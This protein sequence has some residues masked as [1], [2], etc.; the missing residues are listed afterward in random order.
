MLHYQGRLKKLK[1]FGTA[2]AVCS[3]ALSLPRD[4]SAEE[5]LEE[6]LR[7]DALCMAVPWCTLEKPRGGLCFANR[8]S[9]L[10]HVCPED[11][12]DFRNFVSF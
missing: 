3:T 9:V 8:R 7:A 6:P 10:C 12:N 2:K 5:H 11:R 4:T 1:Y